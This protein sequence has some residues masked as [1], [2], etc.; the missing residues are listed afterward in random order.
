[1]TP[2]ELIATLQADPKLMADK[3]AS[4]GVSCL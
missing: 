3:S 4:A 2:L 1:M